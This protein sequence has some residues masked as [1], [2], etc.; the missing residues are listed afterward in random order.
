MSS[1]WTSD[2]IRGIVAHRSGDRAGD[3]STD[4]SADRTSAV[5]SVGMPMRLPGL[6]GALGGAAGSSHIVQ[7]GLPPRPKIA[8]ITVVLPA[9]FGPGTPTIRPDH[10]RNEVPS[11]ATTSPV[12]LGQFADLE[13][14][15]SFRPAPS[16]GTIANGPPRHPGPR[17]ATIRRDAAAA[18]STRVVLHPVEA[19]DSRRPRAW[20]PRLATGR[21]LLALHGD[22][23]ILLDEEPLPLAD[24]HLV[25][26]VQHAVLGGLPREAQ[27]NRSVAQ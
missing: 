20:P 23:R 25:P 14:A 2:R 6:S 7:R 1:N 15:E 5:S 13:H 10:T 4:S 9:P 12:A 24:G 27:T 3:R 8:L 16:L 19:R 18:A 11:S 21:P 22:H 26:P 17:W